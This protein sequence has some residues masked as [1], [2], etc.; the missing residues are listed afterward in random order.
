MAETPP[1]LDNLKLWMRLNDTIIKGGDDPQPVINEVGDNGAFHNVPEG[2]QSGVSVGSGNPPYLN[3]AFEFNNEPM[4]Q[5]ITVPDSAALSITGDLSVSFWFYK[6]ADGNE[7]ILAKGTTDGQRSYAVVCGNSHRITFYATADGTQANRGYCITDTNAYSERTWYHCVITYDA[8]AGT[9]L[10]YLEGTSITFNVGAALPNSI[11]DSTEDLYIGYGF[12]D[13]H[14]GKLDNIMIFNKVLTQD[15]INWLYNGG[16]GREN[17][18][19]ARPLVGGSLA[20]NSLIGRGL[21]R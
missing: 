13:Y 4:D 18:Y 8:S 10:C 5:H 6:S 12:T 16:N 14:I 15:E 1:G 17:P 11:H 3:G 9:A 20:G 21:A 2:D 7:N 19:I